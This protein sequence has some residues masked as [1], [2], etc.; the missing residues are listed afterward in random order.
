MLSF[1][2]CVS[3]LCPRH[4]HPGVQCESRSEGE[5]GERIAPLCEAREHS[6]LC[7]QGTLVDI[8]SGDGRLVV[9]AARMGF[10]A[11]GVEL[12]RW[13]VYYSRF[14]NIC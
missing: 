14:E 11:T 6:T 10:R 8:G 4:D 7:F 12:N 3:A 9:E 5:Q 13:L 1:Q 2:T